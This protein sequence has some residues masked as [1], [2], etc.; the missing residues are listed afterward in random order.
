M[1]M[2]HSVATIP[3]CIL[4]HDLNRHFRDDDHKGQCPSDTFFHS[5]TKLFQGQ[6]V[7]LIDFADCRPAGIV[8]LTSCMSGK[9]EAFTN[10]DCMALLLARNA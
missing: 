2:K 8:C 1:S 7:Q 6:E 9:L 4:S 5:C 10:Y 3:T